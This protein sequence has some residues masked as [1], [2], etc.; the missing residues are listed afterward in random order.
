MEY[1]DDIN[2]NDELL[3]SLNSSSIC[4]TT[5]VLAMMYYMASIHDFNK[6]RLHVNSNIADYFMSKTSQWISMHEE[7]KC[8]R[9][10]YGRTPYEAFNFINSIS[11]IHESLSETYSNILAA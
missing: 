7:E 8:E 11:P 9:D 10:I 2:I 5:H 3:Y 4:N 6:S 1:S